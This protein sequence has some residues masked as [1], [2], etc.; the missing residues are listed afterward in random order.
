MDAVDCSPTV[1][2][3]VQRT[4]LTDALHQSI[5]FHERSC[6]QGHCHLTEEERS[7]G[8]FGD[9]FRMTKLLKRQGWNWTMTSLRSPGAFCLLDGNWH[10]RT[11]FSGMMGIST[12]EEPLPLYDA[13]ELSGFHFSLEGGS[14]EEDPT[15]HAGAVLA[16]A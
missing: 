3:C 13:Q 4:L 15:C 2:C 5:E 8:I 9:L 7:S 1:R 10:L 12:G 16:L 6:K 14:L 11:L